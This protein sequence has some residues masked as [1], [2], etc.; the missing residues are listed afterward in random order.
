MPDQVL[1]TNDL[2]G[3]P[4]APRIFLGA[5]VPYHLRL[6]IDFWNFQLNWNKRSQQAQCDWTVVPAALV[7][8][9]RTLL[10]SN[11]LSDLA[12]DETR[13]YASY[14]PGRE[15]KLK[16]WLTG[17]LD[18][19]PGF[20][21]FIKERHWRQHPIHCRSCGTDLELCPNCSAKLGRASEKMVDSAIIADMLSL[22]W[23]KSFETAI[24][25]SSDADMIPAVESLQ[26]H[27][28]KVI[29][30]TWRG[31]GHELARTSWAS[32]EIDELLEKLKR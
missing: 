3:E 23:D 7:E 15:N 22:A 30:A 9:S 19:Q 14:E 11:G 24:L 28:L 4:S 6:F 16:S 17:F 31:H 18:K 8:R 26:R 10:V 1:S 32:F 20:S 12:L 2:P 27:N 5:M 13:I 21:V 29:N 25:L